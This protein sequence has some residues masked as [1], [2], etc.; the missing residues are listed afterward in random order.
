MTR[1]EQIK[2][3][4]I[5]QWKIHPNKELLDALMAALEPD[6]EALTAILEKYTVTMFSLGHFGTQP[7]PAIQPPQ[8]HSFVQD[9]LDWARGEQEPPVWCSHLVWNGAMKRFIGQATDHSSLTLDDW[10]LCPRC[11]ARRPE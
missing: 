3:V 1:R 6:K 7:V 11:G 5:A 8:G 4:I 10:K 2:E 9:L